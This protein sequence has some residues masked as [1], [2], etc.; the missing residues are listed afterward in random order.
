MM[1]I[2]VG[3][4]AGSTNTNGHRQIRLDGIFWVAHRLAWFYVHGEWPE[5]EID[6]VD[7]NKDYNAITNLREATHFENCNN[8]KASPLTNTSGYKG[9]SLCRGKWTAQIKHKGKCHHLGYFDDPEEAH[10]AYVTASHKYHGQ[11]GRIH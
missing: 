8:R 5:N 6:H 4:V 10:Q 1:K 9:V 2:K 3:Q 7:L 11:F